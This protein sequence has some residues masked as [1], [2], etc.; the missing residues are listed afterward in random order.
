MSDYKPQQLDKKWQ[1]HWA[2]ARAFEV[3]EDP[4]RPKYYCLEMF[5]YPSGHAHVGHVRN[6]IIGDVMARTKR[7]RGFNVLHPFGWDAFG[8]P[9]ENAAIKT[10][11]HPQTS[12]LDNIAHMKGQ[13]QRL[14]ISYAWEREIA[15]CLPEYYKFNQWIFLKMFERGLAYRRRSTVNWCPSC[16]TV[17]ANEQVIDG[18]CWR[19]GS[20]V[21]AR[22]LEQWFFRITA[23]ADELLKGL[24]TLTEWPEKVVVMQRNWIGRSEGARVK[25]PLEAVEP[26]GSGS[27]RTNLTDVEVFTTRI[28]TIYGATFIVLAPEHPL[29]EQFAVASSDPAAFRARAQSFRSQDRDVRMGGKEGFDTGRRAINPFTKRPVPIWVANFVLGEYGTGAIMGVP[30][31]DE[32]DFEFAKAYGLPITIVVQ[33]DDA[34]ISADTM[35]EAHAGMGRLVNSGEFDG[36]PWE[37]ANRRMTAVA[38][39]RGI[40]EG[41]VQYRLKDWGISRQRYWG[42]PIPIIHC[43]K[44]GVVGVPYEDLPVLLPEVTTFTGRG[45]SP[46]AQVPEFV[47]TTC[48][49]CG[50]PARRETDTMDTFVDSSWY[51]LRFCDPTNE[52]LPFE[53]AAAAYWMPVD[54]YS[55]GVEHAILHLLYSRFFTRVLRDVGLVTFDEPF[56]RMLTQGMVLKDG[57]VMSKSK[58]NVVDPDDM[59]QKYGADALR[60][61][62]MFVAPP[63]KEVEWSDSGLEGSLRF[64]YRVWRIVDHW[65]ETIGGEGMPACGDDCT[66]AERALRR[67]THETIQRVTA[68]IEERI[69]LNTAVSS[70]MMLV[71]ELYS[72]SEGTAHGAPTRADP[73]VGSVE[74][75]QT[76]AV[77]CEAIGALVVM[78]APFAPH[79]AEELWERLGHPGGLTAAKWPTF[80]PALARADEV[81]VPV[82][83]NGKVRARL[84][85]AANLS[86][87]GLR[88]AAL[89][90]PAVKAHTQ[91]KM[92]RK[93]VVGKGPIV[94]IVVA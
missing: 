32:R 54:F 67:K 39:E 36:L 9:A 64:L 34:P 92:I 56:K 83:V 71:N 65:A 49:K 88:E 73:P 77:L 24:D 22:E 52:T 55:G 17:L 6:Y 11:T 13:L 5:A 43:E 59:L 29:V 87:D 4:A 25:F 74:R 8:L 53:P 69:H 84:T 50:G 91:G 70:L 45:D 14:G 89:A 20:T 10:G 85:V 42:T 44:D 79:M 58:G 40:G 35:T 23:Y 48:P 78:I 28:D 30:G 86:E 94:S 26:V 61:Y 62:V 19:C 57:A 63:E 46:L 82:Q 51:F 18:T 47:N 3:A 93:V 90:D 27:S 68:D 41:T 2:A 72:F 81:V 16:Q 76:I 37:D 31:H 80:D 38:N 7:L 75:P 12:T 1:R 60:L 66:E 33:P 21:V 15:T